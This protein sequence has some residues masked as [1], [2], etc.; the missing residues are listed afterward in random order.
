MNTST[1]EARLVQALTGVRQHAPLVH[2]LTNTVVQQITANVLLAVGAAPAMVDHPEEAP[3]L[4]GAADAVLLNTGTLTAAQVQSMPAVARAARQA[5]TPW[6]LDPV[7][8][9][10]LPVRT[11]LARQLLDLGPTAI[12]GNASEIAALAGAGQGGRGVDSTDSVEAVL[13]AA[14]ALARRSGAVIAVSGQRD[15][16]VS[17]TRTT[18]LTS[19]DEKLTRVIGTG[20]A[21]GAH[22]AAVLGAAR[23]RDIDPHDAVLAAHAHLGAAGSVAGRRAENI[24]SFAVVWLD[25]LDALEPAE[26]AGLVELTELTDDARH[27]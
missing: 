17:A 22:T 5:G 7:A 11:S 4:A 9:G 6:V 16:I 1:P 14:Q 2:C 8:I 20:C 12:R 27:A 3:V 26:V 15:A 23:D 21:L 25:A 24:G 19:G 18:L 13:P 10:T